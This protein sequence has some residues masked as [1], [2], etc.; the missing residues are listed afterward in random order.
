LEKF[1]NLTDQEYNQLSG[2]SYSKLFPSEPNPNPSPLLKGVRRILAGDFAGATPEAKKACLG[3]VD[4]GIMD[5]FIKEGQQNICYQSTVELR[6]PFN[7]DEPF[8]I[9]TKAKLD[10]VQDVN[11]AFLVLTSCSNGLDFIKACVK[12]G[13][14]TKAAY[15]ILSTNLERCLIVGVSTTKPGLAFVSTVGQGTDKYRD[16][17]KIIREKAYIHV[18]ARA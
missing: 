5:K 1:L 16:A 13:H 11:G 6:N 14:Y 3:I 2:T 15:L 10:F 12:R 7:D 8:E 18:Y 9:N 4:T 17:L